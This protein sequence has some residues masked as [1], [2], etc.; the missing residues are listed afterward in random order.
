MAITANDI[1]T[2]ALRLCSSV[3]PGE[4]IPG[5][6]INNGLIRLNSMLA[7]WSTQQYKIPFRSVD[8]IPTVIGKNSYTIGQSGSPD[9]N[10]VRPDTVTNQWL[11]DLTNP[12]MPLNFPLQYY[13]KEQYDAINLQDIQAI[14]RFLYY[15]PQFPNGII[16]IYPTSSSTN[17]VINLESVKPIM[18]FALLTSQMILPGEYEDVMIYLLGKRLSFEYGFELNADVKEEITKAENMLASKNITNIVATFDAA[19]RNRNQYFS[20]LTG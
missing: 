17:Y 14:P 11:T 10:S 1:I 8:V 15:D 16:N 4:P 7:A 13:T 5:D 2:G 20:I 19:L 3:T 9:F 6:E 12:S 18:Q